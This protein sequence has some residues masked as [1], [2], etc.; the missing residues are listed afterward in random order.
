MTRILPAALLA[1]SALLPACAP[2]Q[3]RPLPDPAT[4]RAGPT[5]VTAVPDLG[6][7]G[8]WM[9]T[10]TLEPATWLGERIGGRTL[11]EPINLLILDRTSATPEAATA[12]LTAAM[13]AAG[14][15]PKTMHSDGYSGLLGERLYP[16]LPPTGKG[17]AFSDGP[18]YVS[19]HHGRVFGPAPIQGGFLFS[20]A[21]SRED[22]RWLPRPGHTYN[23]FTVTREDLAARLAATGVYTR[24]ANVNLGNRLDTPQETTGDHDGQAALL[25]TP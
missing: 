25:T 4:Y 3:T 18:W 14:Y 6:P 24:A 15:G 12:R 13:T 20:A 9:I 21:V 10:K 16:Q 7:V 23:S 11:R 2:T 19:N 5:D 17:L 1:L 22:M 8:R